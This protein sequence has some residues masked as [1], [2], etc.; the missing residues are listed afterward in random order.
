[1]ETRK[2]C[3]VLAQNSGS[4]FVARGKKTVAQLVAF[5]RR[6]GEQRI[7]VVEE[8]S[9]KPCRIAVIEVLETGAWKWGNEEGLNSY[10]IKSKA[11]G[12]L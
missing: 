12:S 7:M 2:L 3:K 1:L 9:G 11:K 4:A 10:E 8:K 5:A 6:K